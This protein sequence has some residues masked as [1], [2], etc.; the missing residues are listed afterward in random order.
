LQAQGIDRIQGSSTVADWDKRYAEASASLFGDAPNEYLRETLARSDVRLS[1]ALMLGDGD[2]RN[3]RWLAQQ[4]IA[5]VAL[6]ISAK[7][8][9]LALE[10]DRKSDVSVERLTIDVD[11]WRPAPGQQW[12]AVFM[13]YLQCESAVR[14]RAAARAGAAVAKGG[15]F[16][17]EGFAP[18]RSGGGELGP[19]NLDLLYERDD[20]LAAL[21]DFE[22]VQALKGWTLLDEGIKHRGRGWITRILA[23][24]R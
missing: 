15:W 22:V 16:I 24:R 8:T 18:N 6:D 9:A 1:S 2:G 13:I 21:P 20:I 12:D 23:R 10:K 3:G 11:D 5:V 7:A 14:N 19:G 4:G 17:A